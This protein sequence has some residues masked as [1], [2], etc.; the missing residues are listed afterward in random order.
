MALKGLLK[1]VGLNVA[2]GGI[3]GAAKAGKRA[4]DAA[5]EGDIKGAAANLA[6]AGSIGP[7][8]IALQTATDPR[9]GAALGEIADFAGL[10]MPDT[11][12][13][14]G[15]TDAVRALRERYA[16]QLDRMGPR[17]AP[18]ALTYG[19]N[20]TDA[21][22]VSVDRVA[23]VSAPQLS[24]V[25]RA[26]A[27]LVMERAQPGAAQ[28]GPTAQAVAE[29]AGPAIIDTSAQAE[30]RADQRFLS[31]NLRGVID[32]TAGPSVAQLQG[33]EAAQQAMNAQLGIAA[34]VRGAGQ[35]AARRLAARNIARMQGNAGAQAA[36]LRAQET[37][38]AREGLAGVAGATRGQD[39]GLA[40]QQA[41][42]TQEAQQQNAQRGTQTSIVNAGAQNQMAT[43]QA[44]LTQD[45]AQQAAQR[46][47]QAAI[48]NAQNQTGVAQQNAQQANQQNIQQGQMGLQAAQGNQQAGVTQ[49]GQQAQINAQI[50]MQNA[51]NQTQTSQFNAG[52]ANTVGTANAN[53]VIDARQ[54][55][56]TALANAQ[57]TALDAATGVTD[58]EKARL[59]IIED[60]KRRRL[61]GATNLAKSG[62]KALGVA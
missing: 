16:G 43:A 20:A 23:D 36:L 28:I 41:A 29:R 21:G 24:P 26:Q 60:G 30:G 12:A 49:A 53:R 59:Q 7:G 9:T 52:Q 14:Q 39:I 32:G 61:E 46:Q 13:I 42:L 40:G 2:T 51:Q 35:N 3:Y 37:A 11:K 1:D 38:Q 17:D 48:V 19:A 56:D 44:G 8:G 50:G 57:R 15:D 31:Q 6:G 4:Y 62:A 55:D 10:G 18:Q 27:A 25:E 58:A 34:G 45:A 22:P 54:T 5:K 47:Q 33:Q